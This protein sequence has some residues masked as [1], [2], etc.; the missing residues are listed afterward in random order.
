MKLDDYYEHGIARGVVRYAKQQTDWRLYGY[1]WMFRPLADLE[2]WEGD[3]I[4]SRV[5][6]TADAERL[7][8]LGLPIVDVAGAYTWAGFHEVNNDDYETGRRAA[9]YLLSC[10]FKRFGFCGVRSTGWSDKRRQGFED[11]VTGTAQST[12]VFEETLPWWERLENSEHLGDWL[13]GLSFPIGIFACNDTAGVK[14]TELCRKLAIP[15][16]D[17]VAILGVDNEDI[18]CELSLPSLSSIE[19]DCYG[20]GLRA[21]GLLDEILSGEKW[22]EYR[23]ILV[24]PKD[25]IER[26]STLV[27]ATDDPVAK[28]AVQYI[29]SHAT[30]GINVSDILKVVPA[31]RR[32]LENRFKA[33]IGRTLHDEITRVRMNHAKGLLRSTDMIVA[34]VAAESGFGTLQRF[35]SIF[36]KETDMTPAVFRSSVRANAGKMA[37]YGRYSSLP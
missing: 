36:K 1:G 33:E 21:A 16:P 35:H 15:V 34:T 28:R 25:L 23:P 2:Y 9:C 24:P 22:E 6:S 32:S 14:L 17:G 3:G 27:F 30:E 12:A 10:G 5:E 31:S 29:R 8:S 4:I 20:I 37:Q 19:L 13:T 26:E 18:L 7:S 11:A